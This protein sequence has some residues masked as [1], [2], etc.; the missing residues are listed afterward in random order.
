MLAESTAMIKDSRS[1]LDAAL[2]DLNL[3]IEAVR[4]LSYDSFYCLQAGS[5]ESDED[6]TAA[7]AA[8]AKALATLQAA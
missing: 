1:R 2:Q 6:L 4:F 3:H 8:A 5:G 7:K